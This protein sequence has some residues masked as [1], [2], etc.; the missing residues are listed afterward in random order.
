VKRS[1]QVGG[2]GLISGESNFGGNL[3]GLRRVVDG[4][5][6]VIHS[7]KPLPAFRPNYR[8]L[9]KKLCVDKKHPSY[10]FI[11]DMAQINI[12]KEISWLRDDVYLQIK[13]LIIILMFIQCFRVHMEPHIQMHPVGD[14]RYLS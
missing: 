5:V 10:C 2:I 1:I 8:K 11:P 13:L 3:F 12:R 7:E 14:G 4:Q 9:K 6:N